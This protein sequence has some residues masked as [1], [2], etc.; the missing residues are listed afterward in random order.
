MSQ[1]EP[2]RSSTDTQRKEVART[3]GEAALRRIENFDRCTKLNPREVQQLDWCDIELGR[4]IGQGSF[5]SVYTASL[6]EGQHFHETIYAL[7][8]LKRRTTSKHESFTIGAVD[9][10]LEA[11]ILSNL[12]HPNIIKLHAVRGGN[13]CECYASGGGYFLVLDLL[14]CTL[15]TCLDGLRDRR[16]R[17]FACAAS[18]SGMIDRLETMALGVAR[19][20]AYLHAQNIIFRDLKPQ[21]VGIDEHGVVRIFD[22]GLAREYHP[23][24]CSQN[25]IIEGARLMTGNCGTPR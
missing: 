4:L 6:K 9:L 22:F 21:N 23:T 2:S 19:G 1:F 14:T 20:M 13:I 25:S 5:S 8:S 17:P 16:C 18:S 11:K 15:E 10:I 7:K 3:V 12:H 24:S